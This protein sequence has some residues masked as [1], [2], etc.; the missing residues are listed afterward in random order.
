MCPSSV[1]VEEL[2]AALLELAL[3]SSAFARGRGH[4]LARCALRESIS[5]ANQALRADVVT[6]D[7]LDPEALVRIY[8]EAGGNWQDLV[9]A[10]SRNSLAGSTA[11][12]REKDN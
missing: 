9:A 1:T 6:N 2:K 7:M 12:K 10:V 4:S 11:R 3:T 8:I 5:Q